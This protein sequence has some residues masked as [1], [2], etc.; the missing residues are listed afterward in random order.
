LGLVTSVHEPSG[1][2]Q[3]KPCT[4]WLG[5]HVLPGAGV[6]VVGQGPL[7]TKHEPSDRQQAR[8]HGF[9]A[10]EPPGMNEPLGGTGHCDHGAV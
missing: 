1:K 5:V 3:T 2:Q 8:G 10:H 9:G 7:T 4:H 6:E